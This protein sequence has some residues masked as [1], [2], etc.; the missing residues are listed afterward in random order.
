M[1]YKATIKIDLKADDGEAAA[2]FFLGVCK[3]IADAIP[4]GPVVRDMRFGVPKQITAGQMDA[5]K[6]A[7]AKALSS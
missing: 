2:E 3:L 7:I 6:A 5:A 4:I 1:I